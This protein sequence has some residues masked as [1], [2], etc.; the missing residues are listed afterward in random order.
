MFALVVVVVLEVETAGT[1]EDE[2][3]VARVEDAGV[4]TVVEVE[5]SGAALEEAGRVSDEETRATGGT[6]LDE[7]ICGGAA[8]EDETAANNNGVSLDDVADAGELT[9]A[10]AAASVVGTAVE[11]EVTAG[12]A[13]DDDETST[14][15]TSEGTGDAVDEGTAGAEVVVDEVVTGA[16][17][18]GAA[19]T[20]LESN[21][22]PN[23]DSSLSA[24]S[25]FTCPPYKIHSI[26]IYMNKIALLISRHRLGLL[27]EEIDCKIL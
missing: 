17:V 14:A 20:N 27:C 24:S 19:A 10:A 8:E 26:H 11:E 13:V 2:A 1:S 16:T 18:V 23:R 25:F 6:S 22:T 4:P 5:A 3:G 7:T 21:F 9:S 15:G 12:A